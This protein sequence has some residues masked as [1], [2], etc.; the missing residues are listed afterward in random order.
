MEGDFLICPH[1]KKFNASILEASH[2]LY[3]H[4]YSMGGLGNDQTNGHRVLYGRNSAV[5]LSML[6]TQ[7]GPQSH[8]QNFGSAHSNVLRRDGGF[9]NT[10]LG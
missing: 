4:K 1:I 3:E 5:T 8:I 9:R 10:L 6:L 2:Y 7:S